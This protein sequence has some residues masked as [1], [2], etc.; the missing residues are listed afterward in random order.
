VASTRY[1]GRYEGSPARLI[2]FAAGFALLVGVLLTGSRAAHAA[3]ADPSTQVTNPK[4]QTSQQVLANL[5]DLAVANEKL[6]EK[7][8]AAQI[9][10]KQDRDAA[11]QAAIDAA[12]ARTAAIAARRDLASS[13]AAQYKGASFSRTAALLDSNSGQNYL[14]TMQSLSFI[15]KHQQEVATAAVDA[16]DAA[17]T[18]Q[19]KADHA[20]KVAEAQ[21]ASV[22][23]QRQALTQKVDEQK[24]LLAQLTAAERAALV[25]RATPAV[26]V[27]QVHQAIV[28]AP[29]IAAA[30]NS[31]AASVAVKAALSRLGKP[32]VWGAGG[33]DSFDCS[34]LTSWAYAQAGISL[35]HNAAAQQGLGTPVSQADLQPGDLVFFGSPAYHVGMYIGNGMMVHAPTT[36]DVVKIS[37]LSYVGDYSGAVRIA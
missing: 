25:R 20:V 30:A 37:S 9:A 4:P 34:G 28:A 18:S 35:P 13:L 29:K 16:V 5:S 15:S 22:A 21:E 27:A 17:K 7:Y 11:A 2:A 23:Q 10:V 8:N 1:E 3:P 33:P 14:D 12:A 24:Q 26:P 6:T 31:A 19:Q 32:Y 36:G